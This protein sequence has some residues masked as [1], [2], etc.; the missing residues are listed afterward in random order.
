M[1]FEKEGDQIM[2]EQEWIIDNNLEQCMECR[3]YIGMQEYSGHS[4]KINSGSR[5][6][7]CAAQGNVV[8]NIERL[9]GRC[10]YREPNSIP[11][12][13]M[14]EKTG[15]IYKKVEIDLTGR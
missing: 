8:A 9:G 14:E 10:R 7:K 1:D 6:L 15:K 12:I 13:G 11:E 4:G 5:R 2:T 3:F